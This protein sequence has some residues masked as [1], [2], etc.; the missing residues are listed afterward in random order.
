MVKKLAHVD[1]RKQADLQRGP[2]EKKP[3]DQNLMT[4]KNPHFEDFP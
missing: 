1:K 4:E 3:K 2:V